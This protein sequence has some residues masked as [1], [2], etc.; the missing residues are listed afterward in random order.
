MPR[1]QRVLSKT[2]YY[3]VIMRGINKNDLFLESVDKQYFLN[4]LRM[5][6]QNLEYVIHAYCLMD[7]HIH[8]LIEEKNST[9]GN[10]MKRI[11]ISYAMYF[12]KKYNRIGPVF[13]DRFKSE[14]VED[15]RYLLSLVRYIHQNPLKAGLVG[16]LQEY[17][18]SSYREYINKNIEGLVIERERVLSLFDGN[19]KQA[20]KEFISFNKQETKER[21]MD[22][23]SKDDVKK[24][25]LEFWN[26]LKDTNISDE[27]KIII[28]QRE[29]KLATRTLSSIT[30]IS[31]AKIMNALSV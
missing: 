12:N 30:G 22:M 25:G 4:I 21:F 27:E 28:M 10:I 17:Q 20:M 6:K 5:K 29:T 31:R 15:D 11:N 1:H 23:G 13:Q 7:N 24:Y 19:E 8:L 3:H 16:S 18:W 26:S 9:I 14:S 2:G